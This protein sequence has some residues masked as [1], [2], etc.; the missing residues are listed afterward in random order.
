MICLILSQQKQLMCEDHNQNYWCIKIKYLP[1]PIPFLWM[2][3]I[4]EHVY[5]CC[6]FHKNGD[7]FVENN[8]CLSQY[9]VP[10]MRKY[11]EMNKNRH[12]SPLSILFLANECTNIVSC[13][14]CSELY[15][16]IWRTIFYFVTH[17]I[18]SNE[19]AIH[20]EQQYNVC[21]FLLS[22]ESF[23]SDYFYWF[24]TILK[25]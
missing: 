9:V 10:P 23:D 15:F 24:L 1:I 5:D 14:H 6:A 2:Q 18:E 25:V 19:E 17:F 20:L 22:I 7:K 16:P 21:F 13:N 8:L 4:N 3:L 11:V 12:F